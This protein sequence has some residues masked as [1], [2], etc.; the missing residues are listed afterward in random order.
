MKGEWMQKED[1]DLFKKHVR[2]LSI[3]SGRYA[4]EAFLVVT[5]AMMK[6]RDWV[7]EGV[8]HEDDPGGEKRQA[9]QGG[10]HISGRELLCGLKK[11]AFEYWG[12]MAP[13][14]LGLW[15][16]KECEDAGEIVFMMLDDPTMGWSKR[17]GD[18]REDFFGGSLALAF[19]RWE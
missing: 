16:I 13:T 9:P 17:D 10:Y 1:T 8:L 2:A 11:M 18:T 19:D 12:R 4:P 7:K 5:E 3:K 6:T 14:V 15:G